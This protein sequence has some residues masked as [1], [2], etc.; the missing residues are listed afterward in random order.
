M[1][2][3]GHYFGFASEP[4]LGQ[5]APNLGQTG[6]LFWCLQCPLRHNN[7][8]LRTSEKRDERQCH[9]PQQR[10]SFTVQ[11]LQMNEA[12]SRRHHMSGTERHQR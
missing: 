4:L 5:A 12:S 11:L 2:P 9:S 1:P 6:L 7:S 10:D 8:S 3:E